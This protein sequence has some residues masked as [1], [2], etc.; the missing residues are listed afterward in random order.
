MAFFS[1][2]T[3]LAFGFL[4]TVIIQAPIVQASMAQTSQWQGPVHGIE[5]AEAFHRAVIE[6]F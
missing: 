1:K 5:Q 4:T 2:H 3:L 6:V